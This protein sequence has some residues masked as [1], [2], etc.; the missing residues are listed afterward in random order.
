M[1]ESSTTTADSSSATADPIGTQSMRFRR[2]LT[3]VFV[4]EVLTCLSSFLV[5]DTGLWV[6]WCVASALALALL[7]LGLSAAGR[8]NRALLQVYC[9]LTIAY[10]V[11]VALLEL[12][13]L[14]F[15][16]VAAH[17]YERR[18][19]WFA[20]VGVAL[21][22]TS[23]ALRILS[24]VRGLRLARTFS[25]S[26]A[27]PSTVA[28]RAI[29]GTGDYDYAAEQQQ[30]QHQTAL[31]DES[32]PMPAPAVAPAMIFPSSAAVPQPP[33]F[34]LPPAPLPPP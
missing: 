21:D 1:A 6:V 32:L 25:L 7:S 5:L 12:A 10:V 24:V 3:A 9:G 13:L 4:L 14:L 33:Q 8:R 18:W 27:D 19:L 15:V 31:H 34:S 28:L 17:R 20:I 30:Q 2:L 29:N 26:H 16:A 23:T 22:A 11:F